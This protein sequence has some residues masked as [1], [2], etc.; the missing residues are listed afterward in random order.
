MYK[1]QVKDGFKIH[2]GE[3]IIISGVVEGAELTAG[4]KITVVG[5]VSGNDKAKIVCKG[6]A[7]I[8]YVRNAIVEVGGNSVSY[9]HLDVYKRQP[10]E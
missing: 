5:G 3:D 10:F 9:T 8:K 7:S 1:R 2:A 4:G 6:D